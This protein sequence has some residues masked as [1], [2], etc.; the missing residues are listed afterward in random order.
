[1]TESTYQA[2][3]LILQTIT[4]LGAVGAVITALHIAK[5]RKLPKIAVKCSLGYSPANES[6]LLI[7]AYNYSQSIVS[8]D[9]LGFTIGI[10]IKHHITIEPTNKSLRHPGFPRELE[11]R[12]KAYEFISW[13]LFEKRYEIFFNRYLNRIPLP[14]RLIRRDRVLEFL[15][16]R[17]RC[18]VTTEEGLTVRSQLSG[19][20]RASLESAFSKNS[21]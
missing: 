5:S 15:L 8:V 14:S 9:T 17:A 2:T 18:W 13:D 1:M 6:G 11:P 16:K 10:F 20:I 19:H 4:A 21:P 3:T 7:T 12:E